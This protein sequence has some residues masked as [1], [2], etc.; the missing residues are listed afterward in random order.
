MQ[1]KIF[2]PFVVAVN[3]PNPDLELASSPDLVLASR[4]ASNS[5]GLATPDLNLPSFSILD[6][7]E[8]P[9]SGFDESMRVSTTLE[10]KLNF[11]EISEQIGLGSAT[12]V[13]SFFP[14]GSLEWTDVD[15]QKK[16]DSDEPFSE[17]KPIK[18]V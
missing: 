1:N 10:A 4:G 2:L 8:F 3:S 5:H 15:F 18:T 16:M 12:A 17:Q 13:R 9:R 7:R 6:T 11:P 14:R